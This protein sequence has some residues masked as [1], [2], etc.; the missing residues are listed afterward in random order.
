M[1]PIP[2]LLLCWWVAG[3]LE[4]QRDSTFKK[5]LL[6]SA[7]SHIGLDMTATRFFLDVCRK[8]SLFAVIVTATGVNQVDW[9]SLVA[10]SGMVIGL[11]SQDTLSNL[12]A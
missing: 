5:Y 12:V 1:N 10:A 8:G 4:R 2:A 6:W 11:A 9:V 3:R 7:A